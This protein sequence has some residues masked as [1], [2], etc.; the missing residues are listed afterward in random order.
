MNWY[1]ALLDYNNNIS[2]TLPNKRFGCFVNSDGL[3]S[4]LTG[5]T[6]IWNGSPPLWCIEIIEVKSLNKWSEVLDKEKKIIWKR[7][8]N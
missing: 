5:A 3:I 4:G 1:Y 8:I 2:V 7:N 6:R